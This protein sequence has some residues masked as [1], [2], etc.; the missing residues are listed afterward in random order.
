MTTN[1]YLT[2]K[3]EKTVPKEYLKHQG[4]D[5]VSPLGKWNFRGLKFNLRKREQEDIVI[6]PTLSI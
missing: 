2:N 3:L 1:I 6:Q 4:L 5:I